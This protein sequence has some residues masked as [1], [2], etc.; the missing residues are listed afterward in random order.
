M[1]KGALAYVFDSKCMKVFCCF[2]CFKRK[3]QGQRKVTHLEL[4]KRCDANQKVDLKKY[5]FHND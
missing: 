1:H 2:F 3:L 5:A 4:I